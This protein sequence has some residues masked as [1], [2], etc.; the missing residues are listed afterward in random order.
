MHRLLLVEAAI[1]CSSS[2]GHL[3]QAPGVL[4]L[5][6][7]FLLKNKVLFSHEMIGFQ[8]LISLPLTVVLNTISR[9]FCGTVVFIGFTIS[10]KKKEKK[11][12]K[13]LS[14]HTLVMFLH[15]FRFIQ[16]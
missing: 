10:N 16:K 14:Q 13:K 6:R 5:G 11:E 4:L 12:R 9:S 8:T 3:K 15:F 2:I 1:G 7:R